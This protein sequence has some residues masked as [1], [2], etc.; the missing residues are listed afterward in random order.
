MSVNALPPD[1]AGL[2]ALLLENPKHAPAH[3]ALADILLARAAPAGRDIT[4]ERAEAVAHLRDAIDLGDR[5]VRTVQL[6]GGA[7]SG[8]DVI[9]ENWNITHALV[10]AFHTGFV[11]HGDYVP[12]MLAVLKNSPAFVNALA[13][14]ERTDRKGL[15]AMLA[16]G[17]LRDSLAHP[18]FTT[19]LRAIITCGPAAEFLLTTARRYFLSRALTFDSAA[20]DPR[21][22]AFCYALADHCFLNDYAFLQDG[23]EALWCDVLAESFGTVLAEDPA[24]D[25]FPAAIV[26]SY[27]PLTAQPWADALEQRHANA[28][29][30]APA[31]AAVVRRH[32]SEPRHERILAAA[33]AQAG[34]V[35]ELTSV[36]VKQFYEENPYPRWITPMRSPPAPSL[37][38]AIHRWFSDADFTHCDRLTRP[39]VLIAGCGTGYAVMNAVLA[40]EDCA[41]TAIDLSRASMAYAK[42]AL[43]TAGFR[44]IDY[45]VCDILEAY[46]LGKQFDVIECMGVLHHMADP[47][48]GWRSLAQTLR[49][50]GIMRIGLYSTAGRR[51]V[52]A[53]RR[54]A[55]AARYAPTADGVRRFRRDALAAARGA[56]GMLDGPAQ[57]L[58]QSGI[59][60]VEDFYSMTMCRDLIFHI[61]ERTYAIP[62]LAAMIAALGL[63]FIGFLS[64][65]ENARAA[66]R[67]RYPH[68]PRGLDLSNW[69]AF[70]THNPSTFA[71]MYDFAVQKPLP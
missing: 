30:D 69:A 32:I 23:D 46:R 62:E 50:G 11:A 24:A 47:L 66:Y 49:P 10:S 2:R 33:M 9:P 53:A 34:P 68:D 42:R 37:R 52:A 12:L 63:R 27:G 44:N 28:L 38:D 45:Q 6:F 29:S 65:P 5:A 40:S 21:E 60:A 14:A 15:E 70:E 56:P 17:V 7:L 67:A 43:E 13:A 16:D 22:R 36:A 4:H 20:I 55:E 31:F 71:T 54:Y 25:P 48:A 59:T 19:L 41:V 3:A 61:Q 51:G 58:A 26:A 57:M 8:I 64:C 39:D 18:I 1:E 35:S